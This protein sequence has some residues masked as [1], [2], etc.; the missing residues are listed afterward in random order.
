MVVTASQTF[1]VE[2]KELNMA[3]DNAVAAAHLA[4]AL[5]QA[6][7]LERPCF[8]RISRYRPAGAAVESLFLRNQLNVILR[9]PPQRLRLRGSLDDAALAKPAVFGSSCAARQCASGALG[10]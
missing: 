2:E 6:G 8:S 9:Q 1:D 7:K 10:Y 4:A 3:D 5:I